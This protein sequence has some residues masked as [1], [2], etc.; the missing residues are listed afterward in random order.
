MTQIIGRRAHFRAGRMAG[1]PAIATAVMALAIGGCGER[2]APVD[3]GGQAIIAEGADLS[4]PHPLVSES[5][6]DNQVN[7]ILYRP[8]LGPSWEDGELLYLTADEH[9]MAMARSYEFFGPDSASLRYRMRSDVRWTDGTPVTAHD[10]AWTLE[11][12]GRP[13]TA[14]PRQDYNR[15][16][17]EIVVE[18][19]STLVIHFTRRYPEIFFHTAGTIAPRHVY[20]GT[21]PTQL[22]S[23]PHLTNPAGNLVTNGPFVLA[24]W[25]RG[26]QVVLERNPD[27]EPQALLDR[28]VFRIIP[29]ETTRMVEIQTGRID[30]TN[31]PF[32]FIADIREAGNLRIETQQ[33]R[34]YEYIAYNP[35]AHDFFADREIRRALSLGVDVT[36]L[37]EGL[38][39]EEF[40]VPA[41]GPYP[42][43]FKNLY[44]AEGQ[45]VL[46]YDTL[47]ARR[48]LASKGWQPGTD[49]ILTKDGVRF[50][51]TL[52]TNGENRRRVDVAQIIERQWRRIGVEAR[53]Q[54]LEFN[55]VNERAVDRNYEAMIGGWGVGL[56]A[57][58]NQMWGDPDL[59]FNFVGYDNPE[60][61]RLF[62]E[63]TQQPTEEAAAPLWR[64]AASLIAADLPYTWLYYYDTPYAINNRLQGTLVNT[65]GQYQRSWEWYIDE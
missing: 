39:M 6:L 22:R 47:E 27:F 16:I 60:V 48:L 41:G 55:T 36:A 56:S 30:M 15:E 51:F 35:G 1:F 9:P 50:A 2:A 62:S 38:Q 8:M 32:H 54:T 28:I 43:V 49:G 13:E 7:A 20:E 12:Q 24:G 3:R 64:Q 58:L 57:D 59:P 25:S 14:S 23:H 44:D 18:D 34:S 45:P 52:L 65:L 46:P 26:Q 37:I 33:N 63:A 4:K 17:R 53:L 5:N 11:T 29:E 42:P 21:D 19:D 61:Q 10:A 31:V 40:A